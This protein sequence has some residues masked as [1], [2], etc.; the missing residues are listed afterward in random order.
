[1]VPSASTGRSAGV[2]AAHKQQMGRETAIGATMR[3]SHVRVK[4]KSLPDHALKS[5][6]RVARSC[7]FYRHV[8]R[9]WCT[10]QL[11]DGRAR[12][13][14]TVTSYTPGCSAVNPSVF[15]PS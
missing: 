9:C 7:G 14:T 4:H 11:T 5:C 8:M 3:S 12:V 2:G 15:A 13:A 10:D 6:R 1:M